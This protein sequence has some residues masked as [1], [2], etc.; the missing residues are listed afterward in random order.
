ME[1][2]SIMKAGVEKGTFTDSPPFIPEV[3]VIALVWTGGHVS[4]KGFILRELA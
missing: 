2:P 1:R 4:E 3:R